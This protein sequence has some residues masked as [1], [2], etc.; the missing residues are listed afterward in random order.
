MLIFKKRN[1]ESLETAKSSSN[2]QHSGTQ[3]L[4]LKIVVFTKEPKFLEQM[5][6]SMSKTGTVQ[7]LRLEGPNGKVIIN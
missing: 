4:V 7:S 1:I 6:E 5:A 2:E 3:V